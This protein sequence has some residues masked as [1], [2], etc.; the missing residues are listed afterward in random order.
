MSPVRGTVM[1][2][3]GHN[4]APYFKKKQELVAVYAAHLT[5]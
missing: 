3:Y 5:E 2:L 4:H 1:T